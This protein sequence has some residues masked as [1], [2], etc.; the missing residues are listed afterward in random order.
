MPQIDRDI[1]IESTDEPHGEDIG[2]IAVDVSRNSG[3]ISRDSA[4]RWCASK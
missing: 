3:M 1:P 4:S 2:Q